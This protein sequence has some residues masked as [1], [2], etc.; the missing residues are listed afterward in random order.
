[1]PNLIEIGID[2]RDDP[3]SMDKC[4][5][6]MGIYKVDMNH[7]LSRGGDKYACGVMPSIWFKDFKDFKD[8][9]RAQGV[10]IVQFNVEEV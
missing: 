9:M 6:L 4:Q 10:D 2:L 7:P 8:A 5:E 1:M 3:K